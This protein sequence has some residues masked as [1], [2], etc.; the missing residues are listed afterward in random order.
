LHHPK[1]EK[2]REYKSWGREGSK[3]EEKERGKERENVDLDENN[4]SN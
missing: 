3:R 4:S 2:E 1:V